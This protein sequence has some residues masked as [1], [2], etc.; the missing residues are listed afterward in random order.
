MCLRIII[1]IPCFMIV[2]VSH[3]VYYNVVKL[4]SLNRIIS[5]AE[6]QAF[7]HC[8]EL[9]Q[10]WRKCFPCKLGRPKL[11]GKMFIF[12]ILMLI[13][14]FSGRCYAN[15]RQ[16]FAFVIDMPLCYVTTHWHMYIK[17]LMLLPL[18]LCWQMLHS[19]F[20]RW[21]REGEQKGDEAPEVP[22]K[23]LVCMLFC[24]VMPMWYHIL[25]ETS[26]VNLL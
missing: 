3:S 10:V 5:L 13:D 17:R 12:I 18:W 11:Y 14:N 24:L 2:N 25:I 15:C 6:R 26:N 19:L 1:D 9:L 16:I 22:S 20:C 8:C 21:Q 4:F 23:L 7:A